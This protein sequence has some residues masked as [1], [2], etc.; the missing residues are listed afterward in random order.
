MDLLEPLS[1]PLTTLDTPAT[2]TYSILSR[3]LLVGI[4]SSI[5]YISLFRN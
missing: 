5:R 2:I 1:I 3:T 4:D